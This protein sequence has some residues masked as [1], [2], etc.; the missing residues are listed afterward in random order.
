MGNRKDRPAVSIA[1][2][3]LPSFDINGRKMEIV[4]TVRDMQIES[5]I[6][7]KVGKSIGFVPTMGY[8]HE[9]HLS[10]IRLAWEKADVV[11]V[12]I[13]VNPT[14][15]GP[16][17]DLDKYPRDFG[18]DEK[19][20]SEAGADIIFYPSVEEMYPDGYA[21]YVTVD[22]LTETLCGASRPGHFQGVTTVCMKLFHAVKP[23]FAVFGQKDAQQAAVIR[24]MVKDLNLDLEVVTGPIVREA[25]GLAMSSRNT[26]LSAEERGDALSLHQSLELSEEMIRK[27]ER[28]P[29]A[30]IEVIRETIDA[31]EKTRIDYIEIVHPE[32]MQPLA[33]IEDE[34]LI[35]LAVFAGKTRLIDNTVVRV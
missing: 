29:T 11:V 5:D 20:A 10:L 1:H 34:A 19:S 3:L 24:R 9:G 15:F 26:Y 8:L 7:R 25:D 16:E 4:H 13:F 23:D 33:K 18:R 21:T 35:A 31:K 17:E 2:S 22:R 32:T 12:S 14:Q 27:G 6:V 28:N 30:I